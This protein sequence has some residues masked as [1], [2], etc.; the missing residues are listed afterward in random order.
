MWSR[1]TRRL[2]R[3]H[4]RPRD[5]LIARLTAERDQARARIAEF[6]RDRQLGYVFVVTYGRSGSTLV[7]GILNSIPGYLIRGENRQ[8]LRH[9]WAYDATG[10]AERR[11]Q[12]RKQR[13]RGAEEGT[14]DTTSPL[15]GMDNYAHRAALRF[16]RKLA[17]AT[18]LRPEPDTRV[19]GFKEIL[20]GEPDTPEFVAWLRE[21]FPEARFVV[22]TRDLS[23]VS[24]S[25][26]WG[27]DPA[28][29]MELREREAMLLRLRDELGDAA[30]HIVYD[31]FIADPTVLRGLFAWLGE[32]FDEEAVR[33]VLGVHHSFRPRRERG[34]AREDGSEDGEDPDE[35]DA[36]AE[37]AN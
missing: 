33:G 29:L 24:R 14:S 3:S 30:Y 34:G 6:E 22:N 18:I 5:E 27:D 9:V 36:A 1:I 10:V 2:A 8:I 13:L 15:F 31:E 12:R 23:S 11:V 26:W 28:A 7:Q 4:L 37:I 17:V 16:A 32:P 21:V 20:W 25:A 35:D 19:T